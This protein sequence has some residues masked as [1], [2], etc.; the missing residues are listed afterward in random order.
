MFPC[1]LTIK[2]ASDNLLLHF[3][4]V[5]KVE[6]HEKLSTNMRDKY[7]LATLRKLTISL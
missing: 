2:Y 6:A 1:M 3:D 5:P 7:G 4:N